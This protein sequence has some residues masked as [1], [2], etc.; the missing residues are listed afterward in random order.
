MASGVRSSWEALAANLFCSATC[1]SSR[2]S[3]ASKLSA[4]S[5]N[6]SLG[7][8]SRI[9]CESEPSAA[10]RVASV[11]RFS[12]LSM[13]PARIHPPSRPNASRKASTSTAVGAKERNNCA[14]LRTMNT[15]PGWNPREREK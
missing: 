5:R 13:W 4:S 14:W 8:G 6:S 10:I 15:T 7:P 3:M 12:G 11:I 2:A 1:A 9:R